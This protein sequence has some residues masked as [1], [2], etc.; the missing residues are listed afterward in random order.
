MNSPLV[1]SKLRRLLYHSMTRN[2]IRLPLPAAFR[3]FQLAAGIASRRKVS[4]IRTLEREYLSYYREGLTSDKSVWASIFVPTEILYAFGLSPLCLEGLSALFASMGIARNFLGRHGTHF[5]PNTMCNFHRLAIDIGSSGI[6]PGPR[7]V[8]ASSA[9]CDGNIKTFRHLAEKNSVPFFFL[10]IPQNDD[11]AGIDYLV[12]QLQE[13][14]E[15]IEALTGKKLDKAKL[16]AAAQNVLTTGEL[17]EEIYRLRCQLR[18]N[19]YYGHQMINFML[20]L[21]AMSGSARLIKICRTIISDLADSNIYNS[22]FPKDLSG[23]TIK[24]VWAHIA[25]VFQYNEVWPFIDDGVRAKVYLEECTGY[26]DGKVKSRDPLEIIA[27]RLIN[28]PGNGPLTKRLDNLERI[29]KDA[30]A[31]GIVHFSHWGCHQA[32]GATPLLQKHFAE[33]EIPFLNVNGDCVDAASCGLEQHK[34][35]YTAFLESLEAKKKNL[36]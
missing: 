3:I 2:G 25:P 7:F 5:V 15:K 13:L 16:D 8:I 10:D 6:L 32:S 12:S 35:R 19:V 29:Y 36:L 17:M 24:I 22:N 30:G 26:L 28:T 33:R 20:P 14:I 34:T 4:S 31:H 23:E 18:R 11:E 9:L 1:D 27:R 21:A